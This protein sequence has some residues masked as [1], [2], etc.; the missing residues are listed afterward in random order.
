MSPAAA[1]GCGPCAAALAV[2]ANQQRALRGA[3][4]PAPAPVAAT[5]AA[6][7]LRGVA[8]SSED[9]MAASILGYGRQE[10]A[11]FARQLD[12]SNSFADFGGRSLPGANLVPA[13]EGEREVRGYVRGSRKQLGITLVPAGR[14]FPGN[15]TGF[16][17]SFLGLRF[18][19]RTK[20][21]NGEKRA[22]NRTREDERRRIRRSCQKGTAAGRAVVYFYL[23]GILSVSRPN[24][25]GPPARLNT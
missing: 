16:L 17:A 10:S 20:E 23:L 12:P 1:S 2:E 7:R 13:I 19:Q 25:D 5:R 8:R 15:E 22:P 3:P 24:R 21:F 6:G 14:R 9:G 11:Y 4:M 18:V